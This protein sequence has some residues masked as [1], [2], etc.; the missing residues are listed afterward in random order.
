MV[1]LKNFNNK[2]GPMEGDGDM[3]LRQLT[4]FIRVAQFQS[5]SKAAASLGYSQ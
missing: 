2:I 3:E 1:S 4:T 5:F